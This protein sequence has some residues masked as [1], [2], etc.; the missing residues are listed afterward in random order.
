[1]DGFITNAHHFFFCFIF[2]KKTQ[3]FVGIEDTSLWPHAIIAIKQF[4]LLEF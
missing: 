1:M 3:Y 2:H 4:L